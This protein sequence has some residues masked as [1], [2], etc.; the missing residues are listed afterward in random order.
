MNIGD[1]IEVE[2]GPGNWLPAT[3]RGI[4]D[5]DEYR[6][7]ILVYSL[8]LSPH[9]E[10]WMPLMFNKRWRWPSGESQ[11]RAHTAEGPQDHQVANVS[12]LEQHE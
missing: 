12:E 5:D 10:C 2:H 8:D 3:V 7:L 6:R 9:S 11:A 1:R 4:E